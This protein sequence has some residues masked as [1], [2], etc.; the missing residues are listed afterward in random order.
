MA[1]R[2]PMLIL[3]VGLICWPGLASGDDLDDLK[4]AQVRY[5]KAFAARDIDA[6]VE[7]EATA[8]GFGYGTAF[9]RL[10]RDKEVFRRAVEQYLNL[11]DF[12][13]ITPYPAEFRVLGSTGLVWGHYGQTTKQKNGPVRTVYLRFAH[14]YAKIDG[15]WKLVLYHR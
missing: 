8:A 3:L 11:M 10:V 14:T 15:Q 9:P 1:S 5:L 13:R 6:I 12:V 7:L 2:G 4:A